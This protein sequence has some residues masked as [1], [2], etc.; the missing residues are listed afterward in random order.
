[1]FGLRNP[2][3]GAETRSSEID[4]GALYQAA[5]QFEGGSYSW[6]R[7]PALLVSSLS[8]PDAAG[9]ST[10]V[11]LTESRRLGRTSPLLL[12]Y[13]GVMET[14]I[15][16]GSPEAPE[17]ADTV[18]ENVAEAAA[19]MWIAA[20][21]CDR[22]RD[23]LDRVIVDGEFLILDTG[24]IVPPDG[25]EPMTGGPK[26]NPTVTGYKVGKA[27]RPRM[28]GLRYVGNRPMGAARALPW[29]APALPPAAGLLNAR[30]GAG[31][32]L[33]I[34]AKLAAVIA[35]ASPDRIT[36]GAGARTGVV[37]RNG[38]T[39]L[40]RQPIHAV[41][42]GSVPFMRPGESVDRVEAGPDESARKYE[43][44]LERDVASALNMPLSEL[45]SDYSS[46]SFSNLRMAWVD[47]E[48]EIARRRAWWHRH[49]RLPLYLD[50]LSTAFAA[51][52]L[53]R[54]NVATMAML[55]RPAWRGPKRQ[56][57]QPEKEA[58]SIAMLVDKGILDP[59]AAR[60]QLEQ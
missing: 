55:K 28:S 33:G 11:L 16:T 56:P 12:A 57:P 35:N 45:L 2:F 47:A 38:A 29:I 46:G 37:D 36:A 13:R 20:S 27:S 41:G 23:L 49:Y 17:F 7:S 4:V 25:F 3:R 21:D 58:Q 6:A 39:D 43:A 19:E 24:E 8:L 26:W 51:G 31:H 30:T 60:E 59:A 42:V 34:M 9:D 54:M 22:E 32:A 40:P 48:R 52:R 44:Q 18:P 10:G 53:P 50:L 14:G 5:F 15:L 1:M